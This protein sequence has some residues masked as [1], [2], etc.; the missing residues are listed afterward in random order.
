MALDEGHPLGFM[1]RGPAG[2]YGSPA[3]ALAAQK[4]V[5]RYIIEHIFTESEYESAIRTQRK[6]SRS[7]PVDTG[8]YRHGWEVRR[9]V[10]V[11]ASWMAKTR[12]GLAAR[13]ASKVPDVQLVNTTPYSGVIEQGARPFWAPIGPLIEWAE[14][15]AGALAL[16]G[17]FSL[18]SR[19]FSARPDGSL[20]FRGRASLNDDD[21][22]AVRAFAY[23]VRGKIAREGLP[24]LWIMRNH[25]PY[26]RMALGSAIRRR[27]RELAVKGRP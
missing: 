14:R 20:R 12:M 18:S 26:A 16:G 1:P 6:I 25:L 19:S 11:G 13:S 24:A 15:K 5:E 3:E 27:L 17:V 22:A 7:G 21:R 2:V 4:R 8:H 10:K 9:R 23:A